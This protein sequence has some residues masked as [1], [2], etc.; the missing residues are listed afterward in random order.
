MPCSNPRSLSLAR[1]I[2]CKHV[3]VHIKLTEIR[4]KFSILFTTFALFTSHQA[5]AQCNTV[6]GGCTSEQAVNVAPH[7]RADTNKPAS[8]AKAA[9]PAAVNKNIQ[10]ANANNSQTTKS[11]TKKM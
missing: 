1:A 2:G 4:L 3:L 11:T 8:S 5:L 10:N 9:A 7:M 6:M